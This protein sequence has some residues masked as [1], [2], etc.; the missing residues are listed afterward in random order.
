MIG[1]IISSC[2]GVQLK[3]AMLG[4]FHTSDSVWEALRTLAGLMTVTE[5]LG[6][7]FSVFLS[8]EPLLDLRVPPNAEES[9]VGCRRGLDEPDE[10]AAANL[11][12]DPVDLV[13]LRGDGSC[14]DGD[15]G[16]A[17]DAE[18]ARRS[19]PGETA[20]LVVLLGDCE[21][22]AAA[23]PPNAAYN[24]TG[25]RSTRARFDDGDRS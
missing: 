25:L 3:L 1:K 10:L 23:L 9:E 11:G 21:D 5:D 7:E 19:A 13:C 17:S 12:M 2:T 6:R 8:P 14:C 24:D 22:D 18:R 15:G 20:G 16:S 4:K